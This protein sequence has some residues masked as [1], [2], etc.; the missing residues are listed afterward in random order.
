[1]TVF[2]SIIA[3][4]YLWCQYRNRPT[5]A[6]TQGPMMVGLIWVANVLTF[7][8]Y[9]IYTNMVA[10]KEKDPEYLHRMMWEWLHAFKLSFVL[11]ALLV[12]LL[13]YFLYRIRGV[14][15]NIIVELLSKSTE[16]QQAI[17]KLGKRYFYGSLFILLV[18][19]AVL[20][21]LFV[22]WGFWEAFNL[23]TN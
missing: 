16:K 3:H 18:V 17:S 14:Y 11:G 8:G 15:S 7:Y 23:D 19:Y 9:Y 12:F 22:Q 10:F 20:A 21:W 4:N 5:L 2:G 6:K 1:M 13:S